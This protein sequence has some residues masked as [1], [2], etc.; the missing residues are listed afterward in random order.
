MTKTTK[1]TKRLEFKP[2]DFVVYPAHGVG[3]I[4]SVE[5]QEISGMQMEF[6]VITFDKDKMTVRV[7]TA[8]VQSVGMRKLSPPDVVSNAIETLRGR[9]RRVG[10]V[11]FLRRSARYAKGLWSGGRSRDWWPDRFTKGC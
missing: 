2:N 4:M 10:W 5:E 7:P 11:A 3:K 9:A 1:K 6:F 8:K